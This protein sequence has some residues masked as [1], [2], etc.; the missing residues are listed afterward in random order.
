MEPTNKL[1][2]DFL[3]GGAV[4]AHQ[5]E[6]AWNKDGKGVSIVDVLSKGAHGVDRIITDG[7]QDDVMYP[8]HEAVDFYSHYKEDITLFAE[9]GF[10]CFRTSIA[11]PRIFPNGDETSP[12]EAGLQFYDELFDELLKYNIEPV[13]TLSHFEMPLHL[14]KHYGGWYNRGLIEFFVNFSRCVFE[15]YQNKVKYWITFNEINNQRNWKNPLFGYCNSGMNYTEFEHP[16]Q[17]MYQVIHHQFVASALAVKIGHEINPK[18]KIGSMIH[19]MPLY[20]AT[21]KPE[22]M[23]QAQQSMREKY[24]FSDVQVRG[25]YP[26]YIEKEWQRKGIQVD[27]AEGDA[28]ILQAGCADFLAISYYMSNIVDAVPPTD[29]VNPLFGAS[30]LNPNL[31]ASE[32]GW[33]ID[34]VGLRYALSELYERYEKP[35]FIVEN[36]FGAVD[37]I[38]P[39]KTINDDYRI[40]YLS[41]HIAEMK[42]AVTLDGVEV[43]GYT[44]WGCID[45]VSFTTGEYMK[46]YGFIYVDKHDDGSGDFSRAKK[47]SFSWYQQVIASNG[48]II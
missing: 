29:E 7:V 6:G 21:C 24:L 3:W 45:C 25:H 5:V 4:A 40:A 38:E 27:M 20:P 43:M 34:P 8:N 19:M 16:E 14:V 39:G 13:I 10:K 35:I 37:E 2:K 18:M 33:Q 42:K 28:E 9:M 44:P 30:R 15:R 36:G 31:E 32:W 48:E 26:R 46:R 23:I 11:W 12:N 41:R 17:V 22:D 47:Q 1:P